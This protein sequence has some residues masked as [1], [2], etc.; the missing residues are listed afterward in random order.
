MQLAS[1]PSP[2]S[3]P[4]LNGMIVE[5]D[6]SL[7]SCSYEHMTPHQTSYESLDTNM[8][9]NEETLSHQNSNQSFQFNSN[10]IQS[11][12][13][14]QEAKK[15]PVSHMNVINPLQVS[16][17]IIIKKKKNNFVYCIFRTLKTTS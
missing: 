17:L 14:F 5:T 1:T 7:P 10:L 6:P 2:D 3:V 8:K 4:V 11:N 12:V 16:D 9:Q 15:N 13:H